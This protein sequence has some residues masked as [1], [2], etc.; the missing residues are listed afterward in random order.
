MKGREREGHVEREREI[1]C[2][3]LRSRYIDK[4]NE[5]KLASTLLLVQSSWLLGLNF[6]GRMITYS[7]HRFTSA[8]SFLYSH[9]PHNDDP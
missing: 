4:Y 9:H 3:D 1:V 8:S 5:V 7:S 2:G 6:R